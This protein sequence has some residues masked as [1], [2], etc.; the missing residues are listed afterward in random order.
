MLFTFFSIF[1]TFTFNKLE[2][3]RLIDSLVRLI[4]LRKSGNIIR[5]DALG[6]LS[7]RYKARIFLHHTTSPK[8][9]QSDTENQVESQVSAI[10]AKVNLHSILR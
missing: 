2:I 5:F 1:L 3:I 4:R 10:L 8:Q 9:V 6:L 7:C